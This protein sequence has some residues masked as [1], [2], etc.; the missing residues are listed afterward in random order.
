MLTRRGIIQS[1][2]KYAYETMTDKPLLQC[3]ASFLKEAVKR[4]LMK[5]PQKH[6]RRSWYL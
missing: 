1:N 3:F 2:M 4:F 5:Y 6:K